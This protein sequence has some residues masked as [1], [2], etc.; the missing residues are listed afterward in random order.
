MVPHANVINL[1]K[2][3]QAVTK[4]LVIAPSGLAGKPVNV[5]VV[6]P[7]TSRAVL[8]LVLAFSPI[9]EDATKE[10]LEQ[11]S[12]LV[13]GELQPTTDN[14][15]ALKT[16]SLVVTRGVIQA[17]RDD[18]DKAALFNGLPANWRCPIPLKPR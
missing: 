1:L 4:C 11:L 8:S 12:K 6:E 14:L 18:P 15:S 16:G 2:R 10:N 7:I 17:L 13:S 3:P 5:P 9:L